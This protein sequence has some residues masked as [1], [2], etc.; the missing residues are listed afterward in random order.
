MKNWSGYW[1]WEPGQ[2]AYPETEAEVQA[3]VLNA[4]EFKKQIR[5][6]GTGHSFMPLW[7]TDSIVLSLDRFQGLVQVDK[8]KCQATIKGGTKLSLLG[9]LL[10]EQGMAMENMGDIDSQSI[11]GTIATGT[12]G[13]GKDFGT[14]STQVVAL[15]F[16]NGEGELINCSLDNNPSLFKAAQV[17]LGLLGV[18]VEVTLQCVPAYRLILEHKKELLS[19][20]LP[21]LQQRNGDNRNFEFYWFPY[22]EMA[23]TKTS[24]IA[25]AQADKVGLM[26]Y[27]SEYV[28][29]NYAFKVLCEFAY[30][31]PSQ[32]VAVSKLSAAT[33]SDTSKVFHSHKIYATQRLVR[34]NEMEYSIP[35]EAHAVVFKE[36]VQLLNSRKF[37][38]HFPIENRVV[39]GDDLPISPASGRDSAYIACHAYAKKNPKPFFK[40]VEE[41]FR[42][43]GGRPHWGKMNTLSA[44]D[45]ADLYPDLPV[46]L[47][48]RAEQDPDQVFINDYFRNLFG[49]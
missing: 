47:A 9:D 37:P 33:I 23:W 16:V 45:V 30:R 18:I 17:S 34:F 48:H 31:F 19:T 49:L 12:H 6:I 42:A 39:K 41:I 13:T 15:K 27:V 29:E 5:M 28:L 1:K 26:N 36:I 7:M 46:F 24:N 8:E 3:L 35:V 44:K 20:V 4:L 11:A 14:M 40:A 21:S 38:I 2:I 22:T 25:K 10:F 43:Y 32:N